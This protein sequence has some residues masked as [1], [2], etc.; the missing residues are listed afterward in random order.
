MK[1]KS[2]K[3]AAA[4]CILCFGL[5]TAADTV[6]YWQLQDGAPGTPAAQD[7]SLKSQLNSPELDAKVSPKSKCKVTFSA[8]VPGKVIV[9]GTDQ[10]VVNSDNTASAQ[11]TPKH[12]NSTAVIVPANQLLNTPSFTV[13]A[14]VKISKIPSYGRIMGKRRAGGY[15]WLVQQ[16]ADRGRLWSIADLQAA[17]DKTRQGRNTPIGRGNI[18]MF[19]D[20]WHHLA[21]TYDDATRKFTVYGDYKIES[22]KKLAQ[23]VVHDLNRLEFFTGI[24]GLIDEVRVSNTALAPADFLKVKE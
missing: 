9:C 5:N 18:P 3:M 14:F 24:N 21:V 7:S 12:A 20:Q 10:A 11:S 6:A 13:E 23:P 4:T 2:I 15:T 19:D 16:W 8:E 17:E 22:S 1:M